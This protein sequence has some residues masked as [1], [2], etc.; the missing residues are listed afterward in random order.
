M[1]ISAT[2]HCQQSY[3][4]TCRGFLYLDDQ[5]VVF[6]L[7]QFL[8]FPR[9]DVW[10]SSNPAVLCV[11][12]LSVFAD[13]APERVSWILTVACIMS[14]SLFQVVPLERFVWLYLG[15]PTSQ[16]QCWGLTMTHQSIINPLKVEELHPSQLS[17]WH[18]EASDAWKRHPR[19]SPSM[20]RHVGP[21]HV[22]L[23]AWT[24]SLGSQL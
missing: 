21:P 14:D 1:N 12:L 10:C 7:K 20:C 4:T 15:H 5:T 17:S 18:L 11:F 22:S 23:Y 13:T 3:K 24:C 2:N 16:F 9:K 8:A 19:M 6:F